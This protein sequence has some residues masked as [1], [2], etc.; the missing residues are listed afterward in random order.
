[1]AS[2]YQ[3]AHSV[4]DDSPSFIVIKQEIVNKD[5]LINWNYIHFLWKRISCIFCVQCLYSCRLCSLFAR[6][7]VCNIWWLC[8][9]EWVEQFGGMIFL[10]LSRK[11]LLI[12]LNCFR[13][14][15]KSYPSS[16][17][18]PT[19]SVVIVF[20][21]EAWSTLLRTVWSI[22][23]RSPRQLLEEVIL[24]DDASDKGAFVMPHRCQN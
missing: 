8:W 5:T 13:C 17:A 20:H 14:K 22:I 23:N 9:L 16:E 24:V 7:V 19:T 12:C 15:K 2:T 21:N 11:L 18:L 6:A 10:V 3:T 1:M 4:H